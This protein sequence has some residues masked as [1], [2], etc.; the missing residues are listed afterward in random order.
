MAKNIVTNTVK[1]CI[2]TFYSTVC[3][4][5]DKEIK[6]RKQNKFHRHSLPK[7]INSKVVESQIGP[8]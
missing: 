2:Q 8:N 5:H 3:I 6:A 1:S 4:K 7:A